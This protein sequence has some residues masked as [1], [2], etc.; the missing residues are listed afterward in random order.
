VITCD[1]C[2]H[3]YDGTACRW[4]CPVCKHKA[5]CCEGA[6]LPPP[7][8][9]IFWKGGRPTTVMVWDGPELE[10][11]PPE[12]EPDEGVMGTFHAT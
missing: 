5:S 3:P 11:D 8:V 2:G 6:P 4:L 12:L 10:E 9:P 7:G 1:S